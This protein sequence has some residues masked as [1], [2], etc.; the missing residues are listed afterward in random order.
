M[1]LITGGMGF[2]GLHT[3]RRFLDA[4]EDV[5]I[6]QFT[7]RR[8]PDF[9]KDEIGKRVFV[10]RVDIT[11][12]HDMIEL[13]RR[14]KVTG[15]VH[16]AVPGLNALTAAEDY[17]VN[18]SGLVNVLEAARVNDVKRVVFASSLTVY[19]GL[20]D[21]PFR[22]DATLPIPSTN[23]TETFKKAQEIL[24]L[25]YGS[26]TGLEAVSARIGG[27]FGPLYHTLANTPSR[28]CLAA[29]RGTAPDFSG[30]RGGM[31]NEDDLGNFC[32][33]KDCALGL[34]LLQT[35]PTLNHRVY[36]VSSG[37]AETYGQFVA[38]AKK[39]AP[40]LRL[41]LPHG[42][43]PRSKPNGYLDISRAIEDVGYKPQYSIEESTA[44]YIN[45]L[46]KNP[47]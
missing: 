19:A 14:H 15:I 30:S 32:Y 7:T 46:R 39:A 34:F 38:A 23:A 33:V 16:L 2:I 41:D 4:G 43:S 21:G 44:D 9:I 36:N 40:D 42:R 35:A 3:A 47:L 37:R 45:W 22:E 20:P 26:R 10:E 17:R 18:M 6:T 11:S 5:V 13:A 28:I 24:A 27:I 12:A 1:I 8:E 25:H 31:P 29:A